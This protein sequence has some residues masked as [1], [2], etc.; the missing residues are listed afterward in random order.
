MLSKSKFLPYLL[1]TF[2]VILIIFI[3]N[4]IL[5]RAHFSIINS[6]VVSIIMLFYFFILEGVAY[7]IFKGSSNL[8]VICI[9]LLC[10]IFFSSFFIIHKLVYDILPNF[11]IKLYAY[12]VELSN[13]VFIKNVTTSFL[14]IFFLSS[15]VA[16]RRDAI[17]S[18]MIIKELWYRNSF[19]KSNPHFFKS[20]FTTAL[21]RAIMGQGKDSPEMLVKL[22]EI[23]SYVL[24][25]EG[26]KSEFISLKKEWIQVEHFIDLM[27]WYYGEDKVML[28]VNDIIISEHYQ[29][30]SLLILSALENANKYADWES[31]VPIVIKVHKVKS[32]LE[33][34][35]ENTFCKQ[36]RAQHQGERS[37]ISSLYQRIS[38]Y[39]N[40]YKIAYKENNNVFIFKITLRNY[41]I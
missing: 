22:C 33:V 27:R 31:E 14:T 37:G 23:V 1:I 25:R 2:I 17:K 36:D 32:D 7:K 15:V 29:I 28:T 20:L 18:H 8:K 19:S 40:K 13:T 24:S 38:R 26:L 5:Y 30:I 4:A 11:D 16:S 6:L 39:G 41:D 12:R 35:I 10:I 9:L 21:C 34:I 3:G